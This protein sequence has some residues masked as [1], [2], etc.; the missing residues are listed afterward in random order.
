MWI[1]QEREIRRFVSV[2]AEAV[3]AV[4]KGFALLGKG[5][6]ETPPILRIDFPEVK[7]EV[8]VKT[9]AV[10]GLPFF[11]VK[12]SSGF[13]QNREKGLPSGNGMM[14]L[15]RTDTGQPEAVLLDNGYLTDVRTSAAGAV[16]TRHLAREGKVRAGVIG[17]GSQAYFQVRGLSLVREL[18]SVSVWSPTRR[19]AEDCA[20]RLAQELQLDARAVEDAHTVVRESEIVV[21]ATPATEAVVQKEWLHP[22]LHITA[23]GSDAGHKRELG[24]GVL[25]MADRVVCDLKSQC[26]SFGELRAAVEEGAID[27]AAVAEL[28]QIVANTATGRQR[29]EEITI[30]DLTG[31]GVQDTMI[32]IH[33]YQ[34][35]RKQ[36]CGIGLTEEDTINR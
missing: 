25:T 30:C 2:D 12:I 10:Q 35:L 16:A 32:A 19:R 21:T 28:G 14:V 29:Q 33:A 9:A 34:I 7:G 8:D 23:M 24:S 4:E 3:A 13:F 5:M 31:T 1:F 26:L 36:G 18:T 22:G 11:A 17:A 27:P 6:V 20:R 15:I